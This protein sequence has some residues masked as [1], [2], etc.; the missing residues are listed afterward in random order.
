VELAQAFA[1][2]GSRVRIRARHTLLYREDPAIGEALTAAFREEGL[3]VPEQTQASAVAYRN[4]EFVLTTGQ[5]EL[6]ADKVLVATGRNPNTRALDLAAAGVEVTER[7]TIVVDERLS[8]SAPDI[9]AAGDLHKPA[10]VRLCR[11]GGRYPCRDQHDA[12]RGSARSIRHAGGGIH[13]PAGRDR[14]TVRSRGPC[15]GIEIDTRTVTLDNVPRAPANFDTRG[16]IKL[17]MEEGS[18]RLIGVQ[19]AAL[20]MHARMIVAELAEQLFPYLTMVKGLN[21][22]A[23]TFKQDVWQLSC[24]AG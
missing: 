11:S 4:G 24:C 20:A 13:R 23:Q 16:F 17:V 5:G 15:A 7:G 21:L 1:R 10:A 6:R 3:E 2:L 9:Y 18:R 14:W 8:T 19:A 22:T 12:R